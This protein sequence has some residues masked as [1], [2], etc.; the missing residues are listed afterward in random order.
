MSKGTEKELRFHVT[1]KS[2]A[3]NKCLFFPSES[4]TVSEF[5]MKPPTKAR[6]L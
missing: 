2:R 5:H 3:H 6:A 4:I 1:Q